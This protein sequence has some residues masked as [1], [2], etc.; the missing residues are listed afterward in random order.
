MRDVPFPSSL[1]GKHL[2]VAYWGQNSAGGQ[3]P[4]SEKEL[5][6]VCQERKYDIIVIA[7]VVQFFGKNN[8]GVSNICY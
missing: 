6:A 8:K 7:F 2:L 3:P 4:N 5:K 1:V